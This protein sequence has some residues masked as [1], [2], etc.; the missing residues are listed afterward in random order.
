MSAKRWIV[1]VLALTAVTA[2][3]S[4][5]DQRTDTINPEQARQQ[6]ENMPPAL[7]AQLD[8]G[9]T[10]FRDKSYQEALR[11]YQAATQIDDGVAAAWFGVYMAERALGNEPEALKAMERVE[12]IAP[13]ATLVHPTSGDTA[14]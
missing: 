13:G 11:H 9:S 1:L 7:V 8:S 4:R 3:Q 6:R 2:C 14:R 10:S 12:K 5:D